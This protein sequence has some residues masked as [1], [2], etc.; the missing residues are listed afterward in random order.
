MGRGS[1]RSGRVLLE[2]KKQCGRENWALEKGH[3]AL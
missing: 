2:G 3:L 1:V